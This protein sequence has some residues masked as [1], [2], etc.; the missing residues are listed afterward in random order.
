[1]SGDDV[2]LFLNILLTLEIYVST[3]NTKS[4]TNYCH[5]HYKH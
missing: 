5:K 4:S 2:S 1:M 3:M